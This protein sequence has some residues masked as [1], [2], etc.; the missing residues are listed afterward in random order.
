[1]AYDKSQKKKKSE[2]I[3]DWYNDI[4]LKAELADY[5]PVKGTMVIRPYGYG[6]WE[7]LQKAMDPLIKAKGVQNAY[8][9]LFIP[10]SLLQKEAKH[11][12]GF[13]PELAIVTEGGGEKLA[14]PLAVRPTS[15]TIMYDMYSKWVQSWRDLPI[16]INQ[17]NNVVRWEKRTYLFLRTSEFLWQEGHTAHTTHEESWDFVM[18]AIQ[19]YGEIY[20]DYFAIPGF[21][22]RKSELEKFA[23]GDATLSYEMIMPDGKALQGCTSHDLGQNFS[24]AYNVSFQDK[25]LST[26]YAWQA[27]WGF[28]TRSIGSLILTHGDDYGLRLPPKLA[29]IQVVILPVK[30]LDQNQVEKCEEIKKMLEAK[31]IRVAIDARDDETLGFRINKWEQKG[32]PIRLEVGD[33]ELESGEYTLTRRDLREKVKSFSLEADVAT[34]LIDIQDTLYKQALENLNNFLSDAKSYEEFK[35]IMEEKRGFIRAFWC[36]SPSCEAKIKEETKATTRCLP[37][38]AKEENGKCVYCG[39]KAKYKWIFAQAY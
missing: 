18:W 23:G 33:K 30:P 16:L 6:I 17:W 14:E 12:E 22:G 26:S 3:S 1:M 5:G 13:S 29:P 36:E 19:M 7:L 39:E 38:D 10:I 8:F 27:S 25:D 15:E 34:L 28:T 4:V 37:M 31:E 35:K 20:R 9:P 21:I 2:N 24:K 11:V 32:V